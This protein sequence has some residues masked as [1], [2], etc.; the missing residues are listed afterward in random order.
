[1]KGTDMTENR[2]DFLKTAA[3]ASAV[4]AASG[5]VLSKALASQLKDEKMKVQVNHEWGYSSSKLRAV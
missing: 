4:T 1:M 2:R 3:V 5:S